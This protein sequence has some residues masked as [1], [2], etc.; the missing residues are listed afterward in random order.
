MKGNTL[1]PSGYHRISAAL[2]AEFKRSRL[3]GGEV[4]LSIQGTIGR[5]ALVPMAMAGAN[6]SRTVAIVAPDDSLDRRYLYFYFWYLSLVDGYKTGGSTRVSLNIG[7]IREMAIP[8]PPLP[9]Q[10]RIVAA[11]EELFSRLDVGEASL[12]SVAARVAQLSVAPAEAVWRNEPN[13]RP[14]TGAGTVVTGSTP[15]TAD[16]DLW[17]GSFPFVTPGDLVHGAI[18]A[19]ADRRLSDH[20][21]RVAREVPAGSV[22]VTCIGATLGKASLAAE[23]MATNQQINTLVVDEAVADPTFVLAVLAC[24]HGQR[25]LWESS[26]STTLPILNKTRFGQVEIPLP[27]R[28]RQQALVFERS[29][30]LE[31]AARLRECV[32]AALLRAAALRRSILKSAFSGRLVFQDLSDEPAS[33]LLERIAAERAATKPTRRKKAT[34]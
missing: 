34:S 14:L 22:L 31:D 12:N 4:L 15:S 7:T 32:G 33:V 11:I 18:A 17:G 24:P 20:G 2:D 25:A 27:S 13:R 19:A 9:E 30:I 21:R 29:A 10:R 8:I 23:A 5:T 16:K 1:A 3:E 26:S 28:R 6:V